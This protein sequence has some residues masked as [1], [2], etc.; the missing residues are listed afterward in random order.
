[1]YHICLIQ[2][3]CFQ[4]LV[5][6][7][8]NVRYSHAGTKLPRDNVTTVIIKDR[9]EIEPT[10]TD[11]LEISEVCLPKL[12]GC[13][14][15]VPELTRRFHDNEGWAGDQIVGSQ[16]PINTGFRDEVAALVGEGHSQFSWA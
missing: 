15:L 12:I 1:M 5:Q 11:D 9:A 3:C 8:L 7:V 13:R 10:P 16:K 6:R 14:G 2:P 4:S